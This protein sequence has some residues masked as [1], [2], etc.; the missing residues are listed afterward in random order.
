MQCTCTRTHTHTERER[1][2]ERERETE[3]EGISQ[4]MVCC[5]L[6]NALLKSS[7]LSGTQSQVSVSH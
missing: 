2:R 7:M 5:I 6:G 3:T 4:I 1:E